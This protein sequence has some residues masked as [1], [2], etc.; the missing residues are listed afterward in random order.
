MAVVGVKSVGGAAKLIIIV[1][2]IDLVAT[3]LV[4]WQKRRLRVI[5]LT[6]LQD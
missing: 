2:N 3:E 6:F 5:H 1:D 4:H